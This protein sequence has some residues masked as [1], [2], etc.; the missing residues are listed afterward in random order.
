MNKTKFNKI[1]NIIDLI[2][3]S[4]VIIAAGNYVLGRIL[5]VI[6]PDNNFAGH[7]MTMLVFVIII[8][9]LNGCVFGWDDNSKEEEKKKDDDK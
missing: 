4:I 2:W 8:T 3:A 7:C 6:S 9:H 5:G 1:V